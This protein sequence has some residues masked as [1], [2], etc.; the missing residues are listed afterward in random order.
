MQRCDIKTVHPNYNIYDYDVSLNV[1]FSYS[2][3]FVPYK[4]G[5]EADRFLTGL[6]RKHITS[7]DNCYLITVL[8]EMS[9]N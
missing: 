2:T 5:S 4:F 3:F 6:H 8:K 1:S 7:V 9:K